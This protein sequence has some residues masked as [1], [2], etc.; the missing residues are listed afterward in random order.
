MNYALI[1]SGG[2]GTRLWPLS[3]RARPKH[4]I[5][6]AGGKPLLEQTLD[7]LGDLIPADRRF[8]ITIPEQA[9]IVRDAAR[10]R[11]MGIIIEPV[12]RNNLFPMVLSTKIIAERD[13][14]ARIAFL[15]ADHSMTAP[16]KL[17]QALSIAFDVAEEGYIVTIG[18][19]T[20]YPEPNYGHVQKGDRIAGYDDRDLPV[21][22]VKSFREKPP[23]ETAE[24]FAGSDEWYWNSGIFVF[25]ATAMMDL[26]LK[27]Q[28]ELARMVNDLA[29]VLL[30]SD[31]TLANPVI[32]WEADEEIRDAYI[33]LPQ[34]FQTSIDYALMEKAD[35]VATIP[36]DMGWSDLGGFAALDDLIEP[37][38]D[39]T[40]RVAP[41]MDGGD[42]RVI[43]PGCRDVTVF[44]GRRSIVCLDCEDLIVVDTP[45]ALL[46][47]PKDSSGKVRDVI[48]LIKQ[49]GW[50]DLL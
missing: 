20:R 38:E 13:E 29:H 19:P 7:R 30:K 15:P 8:L 28:P 40:N 26:V 5:N 37:L 47:L 25:S 31:S 27:M 11:A 18:I 39:E 43:L 16:E 24:E 17:G 34:K 23:M 42:P 22:E 6:L 9:P 49:R 36:V 44:P 14:D 2:S 4:L 45:D 3:R 32:D 33:N 12:G 35:R 10:G 48:D 1:L 21:Y 50:S 46:I 41:R